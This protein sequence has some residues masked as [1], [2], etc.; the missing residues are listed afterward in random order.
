MI[1]NRLLQKLQQ[2]LSPQ[3]IQ[4]MKLL[5]LPT[6]ALEQRI[7]DE[8]ELNPT[9]EEDEEL[10]EQEERLEEREES[11]EENREE[12]FGD[13]EMFPNDDDIISFKNND[14]NR[15][16]DLTSVPIA[17][18]L[19]FYDDLIG[20]ISLKKITDKDKLIA[21]EII[22][23]LDDAGYLGRSLE[24]ISDDFLFRQNLEIEVEE[25]ENALNMVQ[26]LDPP[27]IAARDL[28]ESLL[29]QIDRK[30]KTKALTLARKVI[31]K[32]FESFLNK[33]YSN[34]IQR[35]SIEED[36]LEEALEEILKLNPKPA[37]SSFGISSQTISVSPDFIVW[38]QDGEIEFQVNRA[39]NRKL[40]TNN[41]Y[42]KL[43]KEL[44]NSKSEADKETYNFLKKRIDSANE[45]IELLNMRYDTLYLIMKTIIEYQYEYMIEG[46]IQKL[47]PMRLVDIGDIIEMDVSTV[48]RVISNKYMQ[49][50]FGLFKIKDL[51]SNYMISDSGVAVSTDSIRNTMV[52]IIDNE[53]KTNPYTDDE[54]VAELKKKGYSIARRTVAKYRKTLDIPVARLRRQINN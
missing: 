36:E 1:S 2:K 13:K 23:N 42:S 38:L 9:L 29:L 27:G 20:Q 6:L 12:L 50:H 45:F 5:Q 26:S 28:R 10:N 37:N 24:A 17:S 25:I 33:Q 48:S 49:T 53:D 52:Q 15:G 22:G 8:I 21:I 30:P 4:L 43:M 51:F 54:V 31:D 34:I 19:S 39:T 44:E 46:D 14:R 3:Q 35:L 47:K 16:G 32:T 18:E 40:R 11:S 41:Y 7:K